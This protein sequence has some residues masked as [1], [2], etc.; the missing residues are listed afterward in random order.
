[1]QKKIFFIVHVCDLLVNAGIWQCMDSDSVEDTVA[2][3]SLLETFGGPD[4]SRLETS[5][6]HCVG[7]VCNCKRLQQ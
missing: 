2:S 5:S 7:C 6:P 1:M 3:V 4:Q